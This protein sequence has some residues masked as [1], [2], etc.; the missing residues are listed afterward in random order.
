MGSLNAALGDGTDAYAHRARRMLTACLFCSLAVF[1]GSIAGGTYANTPI[2]AVG[3]FAA[4][5]S[6]ALGSSE[7]DIGLMT[8]VVLIIFS[9]KPLSPGQAFT[10]GLFA[11]GGGLIQTALALAFW[12][13]WRS[14]P[15]RRALAALYV[16]LSAAAATASTATKAP[17]AS[18][19]STEAQQALAALD[20]GSSVES[21]SYIAL[22]SQAERIRLTLLALARMRCRIEME[23]GTERV[24]GLLERWSNLTAQTLRQVGESLRS[25]TNAG[26]MP[27]PASEMAGIAAQLGQAGAANSGAVAAM[28][29]EGRSL[30]DTLAA[31]LRTVLDLSAQTTDRGRVELE[32]RE[33]SH[34]WRLQF[35]GVRSALQAALRRDSAILH[36]AVRLAVCLTAG[37]LAGRSLHLERP[38]WIPM[39]VALVL[40]PDFTT[41]FSRG[42]QRLLGTLVGLVVATTLFGLLHPSL[43]LKIALIAAFAFVLRAYGPANYGILAI[44]VTS[45]VVFRFAYTGGSPSELMVPRAINTIA[46]GFVA[47]L[48]Y[49]VWP[50]WERTQAPEAL[51]R[52]LN[53]YRAYFQSVRDGYLRQEGLPRESA[54]TARDG[55]RLAARVARS[56]FETSLTRMRAEP[57]NSAESIAAFDRI[58]AD[59][60]RFIQAVMSLESGL[61]ASQPVPVRDA[62]RKLSN[63]VDVTLYYLAAG[64]RGTAITSADFADLRA[65]HQALLES[66]DPA[67]RRYALV[68]METDRIVNSLNTVAG[69]IRTLVAV[70]DAAPVQLS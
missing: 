41:T 10:S 64:L 25:Q 24:S 36:H 31:Q 7:A 63:D 56:N 65:D 58:L 48:G 49:F 40:K 5:M 22:L 69:H 43:G 70:D 27:A 18:R 30:M 15:E 33:A 26:S 2:L 4:G 1:A 67:N 60:H 68:N 57:G 61:Y 13:L 54:D 28:L 29:N 11:L 44:S 34:P 8:L 51:A 38:Y 21:A 20:A 62:F 46:G 23:P 37:E 9:V 39:T 53:A 14:T 59:S 55:S 32:L 35:D 3:A 45:M 66:G 50:T 47:L 16:N 19:A 17:P 52:M 12:P 6:V 42:L